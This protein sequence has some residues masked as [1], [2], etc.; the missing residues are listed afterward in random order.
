MA[1]DSE[2][3][4]DFG[5]IVGQDALADPSENADSRDCKART[6]NMV[7]VPEVDDLGYCV[8]GY[9]VHSESGKEYTIEWDGQGGREDCECMDMKMNK[10]RD[11]CKHIRRIGFGMYEGRLPK[12]DRKADEY[13]DWLKQTQTVLA[14]TLEDYGDDLTDESKTEAERI[15]A[16]LTDAL[17]DDEANGETEQEAAV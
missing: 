3:E 1:S 13:M 14:E 7:V 11:G 8:G 5:H 9:T 4:I 15:L 12:P 2:L 17:A 6:E 16:I 10:P